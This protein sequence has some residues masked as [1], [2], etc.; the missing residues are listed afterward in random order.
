M[1]RQTNHRALLKRLRHWQPRTRQQLAAYVHAY[2]GLQI[3]SRSVCAGHDSPLDY[4]AW[5]FLDRPRSQ[6]MPDVHSDNQQGGCVVWANRGGGKTQLGAIASL[7]ECLFLP[8]CQVRILGGSQMQSQ[9]MYHHLRAGL[10]RGYGD[11]L[12]GRVKVTGCR[13]VNGSAVQVLAQSDRAVRGQ[14]VQRL[15]CDEVEL[16]EPSVWQAA[17]FI[18]QSRPG[19]PGRLEALSTMHRPFGLMHELISNA[20]EVGLKVLRWCLWEV[21]ERCRERN[22]ST[23]CLW[24]DCRG[25]ARQADGYYRIDDA[26]DQKRRS[27]N[28][29][30]QAEMLC[31]QP[32][33]ED[34]VFAEFDPARHVRPITY[35]H[36]W[37][38]YR[39]IDF[40]YSNPLVCLFVQIDPEGRVLVIDEHLKSRTTLSEHARLIKE[41]YP[42]P[43]EATY[44]DPAGRARNEIT[45]TAATTELTA[46]GIPTRYRLSRI[47]DGV[48]QIRTFLSPAD[49]P[50]RLIVS[51]KCRHLIAAFASL[52]YDRLSNGRLSEL[53]R[54]D[55]THDHL[56]DALRYFFVNR[57]TRP[58]PLREKIY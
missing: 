23:C 24:Q 42:Y 57:F 38:L 28:A 47:L 46:L 37:P 31:R 48:E 58:Y 30:W 26:I 11:Q 52:Q 56:I 29:A 16:F 2:L 9:Q 53:P 14:H 35:Q 1:T 32:N 18:T 10:D 15:R 50:P 39:T 25:R 8:S 17:Q 12:A 51:N 43:V 6:G 41:R 49:G 19:I 54:K 44:C 21:I 55:G 27:S 36:D 40:G 33:R 5:A 13:F 3:P 4:L 22:C 20:G 45:G 7:L 34:L